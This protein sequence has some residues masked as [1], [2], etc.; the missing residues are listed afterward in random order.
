MINKMENKK[1]PF[2]FWMTIV[3]LVLI[4]VLLFYTLTLSVKQNEG[5]INNPTERLCVDM[6]GSQLTLCNSEVRVYREDR[7]CGVEFTSCV[8]SCDY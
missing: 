6:C 4:I 1:V 5:A 8:N 3:V 2:W 7:N